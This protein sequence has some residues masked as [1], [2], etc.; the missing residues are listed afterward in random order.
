MPLSNLHWPVTQVSGLTPEA[1]REMVKAAIM[2]NEACALL[3]LPT[4]LLIHILGYIVKVIRR[5]GDP[6]VLDV[7]H[8]YTIRLRYSAVSYTCKQLRKEVLPLFFGLNKFRFASET[9]E[10]IQGFLQKSGFHNHKK[11]APQTIDTDVNSRV[12]VFGFA[13]PSGS[14]F[15]SLANPG[16]VQNLPHIHGNYIELPGISL[17]PMLK[18]IELVLNVPEDKRYSRLLG[19]TYTDTAR[20]WLFPVRAIM[21]LG[22]THLKELKIVVR[23]DPSRIDTESIGAGQRLEDWLDE[24]LIMID[25]ERFAEGVSWTYQAV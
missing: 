13:P 21:R 7:R 5:N 6:I 14:H 2:H 11:T 19:P 10:T 15:P 16:Y 22:F 8:Y 18:Q 20:D 3:N 9:A 12:V 4:E 25:V 24:E 1:I 17:R 23:Y